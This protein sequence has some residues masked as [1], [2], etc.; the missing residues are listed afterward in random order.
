MKPDISIIVPVYNAEKYLRRCIDSILAQTLENFELILVDDG[1]SDN[2]GHICDE[3]VE[4]D[5][6]IH[7]IHKQNAGVS[8]ARNTGIAASCGEFIGFVDADDEVMSE[9][10][11]DMVNIAKNNKADVVMCDPWI[12]AGN[13][14][15]TQDSI[16]QLSNSTLLCKDD[17]YPELLRFFAGTI[18]RCIYAKGLVEKNN[19]YFIND[20]KLSEDRIFNLT[21]IG[22]ADYIYYYRKP[23]YKYH[24]CSGS[25]SR[26]YY[27]N[28]YFNIVLKTDYYTQKVLSDY[29]GEEYFDI[30]KELI[31]VDGAMS[32]ICQICSYS[33]PQ[34]SLFARLRQIEIISNNDSLMNALSNLKVINSLQTLLQKKR[35]KCLYIVGCLK[36][37]KYDTKNIFYAIFDVIIDI[38]NKIFR[39]K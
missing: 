37:L 16:P 2:S 14:K 31:V 10:F 35:I 21:A 20:L 22:C 6:R 34:K 32:A 7:V 19:I 25:A 13:R 24:I 18:W 30:Y 29:W 12:I 28:Y 33:N 15:W 4:K 8:S 38:V 1:S 36:N 3:Y 23:L 11:Y 27:E 39:R 5:T 17:F 9:M 26:K